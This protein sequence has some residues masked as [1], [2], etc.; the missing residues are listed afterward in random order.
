[1]TKLIYVLLATTAVRAQTLEIPAA[2]V[3]RG[4]ANIFRVVLR[5]QA[6]KPITAL[7]WELIIPPGLLVAAD[8]VATGDAA[9]TAGKSVTCSNRTDTKNGTIC[10]CIVAGGLKPVQGGTIAIVKFS[11]AGGAKAGAVTIGLQRILGVSADLQ[12]VPIADATTAINIR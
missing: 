7:Q 6:Q 11:A 10:A 1:V 5:S 9:E 12:K 8:S 2:S 3:D 4:S